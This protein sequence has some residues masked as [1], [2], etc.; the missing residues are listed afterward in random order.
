ALLF[1]GCSAASLLNPYGTKLHTHIVEYLRSD[2]IRNMIQEFQAPT[3]RSEG[4]V[5]FEILLLAG[6]IAAGALLKRRKITE[7]LWLVFLAH[8]ALT[9]VRHA[10]LY[11]SIAAPLLASEL[12]FW[13]R[14]WVSGKK[15]S[16][17]AAIFYQ[18]GE[19]L[20]PSFRRTTFWPALVLVVVAA[21]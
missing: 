10:P 12:T 21:I 14:D 13:W 15:K 3:F 18:L 4:Q 8:S 7:F 11:A 20:T 2:W 16:S 9:S 17:F 6:L 19:D 5:Q 1:L